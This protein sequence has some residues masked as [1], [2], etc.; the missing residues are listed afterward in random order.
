[1]ENDIGNEEKKARKNERKECELR[2]EIEEGRRRK[3]KR[4]K[5]GECREKN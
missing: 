1:M 4:R 3:C 2:E 5:I